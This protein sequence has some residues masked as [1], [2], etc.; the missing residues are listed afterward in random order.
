VLG[1]VV[2]VIALL[3]VQGSGYLVAGTAVWLLVGRR[4]LAAASSA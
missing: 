1:Q 4:P 2:P 3:V